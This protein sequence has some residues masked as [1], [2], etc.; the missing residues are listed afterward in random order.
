MSDQPDDNNSRTAAISLEN[1]VNTRIGEG[2]IHGF[3]DAV[4]MR[5]C[6]NTVIDGM[7][8][9]PRANAIKRREASEAQ[10][11]GGGGGKRKIY[12]PSRR[13]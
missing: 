1:C 9:R 2:V 11:E 6:K 7:E 4:R 13:K 12:L 10:R 8:H 3:D 5:N